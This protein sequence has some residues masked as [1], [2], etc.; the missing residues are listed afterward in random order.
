MS[1]PLPPTYREVF[2][3]NGYHDDELS[4]VEDPVQHGN[5]I[6]ATFDYPVAGGWSAGLAWL[7]LGRVAGADAFMQGRRPETVIFTGDQTPPVSTTT[8]LR[9][10]HSTSSF[11]LFAGYHLPRGTSLPAGIDSQIGV[12]AGASDV[13]V[14][15]WLV[16]KLGD[17]YLGSRISR[18]LAFSALFLATADYSIIDGFG[19]GLFFAYQYLPPADMPP[20]K[21]K[22]ETVTAPSGESVL[23]YSTLKPYRIDFSALKIGVCARFDL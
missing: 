3:D 10:F 15:F 2:R 11:Y 13:S 22:G 17:A 14:E 1:F 16:D 6:F 18:P 9:E 19:L 21:I 8:G 4:T 12:G 20:V 5:G 23:V 7:T